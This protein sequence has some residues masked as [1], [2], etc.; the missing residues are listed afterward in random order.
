MDR[1][2]IETWFD[3]VTEL[4]VQHNYQPDCIYNMDE[5]GFAVGTSQ[6]SR[7]LVNIREKSSWKI[8][9]GRQEWITA[10]EC[11]SAS[12]IA[13]PPLVI[14]KAKHTNSA[15]IPAQ[16]PSNWRFS[17]SNSGWTS[18]SHGY[19]WLTAVFEPT[20]RPLDPIQRRLLIMDGH[21]S[22]ITANFIAYCIDKAIDMLILPPH[23]SHI[24]QPL[25]ISIFAP[26]KRA[27]AAET[28]AV[29]QLDSGR[30]S[31]VEWT[32]MY[33]RARARAFTVVNIQ[34]GWKAS[35]LV[36][37]SPITVLEKYTTTHK[38]HA[39]QPS[40]ASDSHILDLSLLNSSPP[41]RT[42]LR[43]ANAVFNA[44][45]QDSEHLRTPVK[46]YAQRMTSAF[47][48]TQ[49]DLIT[50][51]KRLAFA[52]QLLHTR[53]ARKTGKRVALK[54]K[55]VFSTQEVLQIANEAEEAIAAKKRNKERQIQPITIEV[56][57]I[58]DEA[59]SSV[60]S[61]CE[62]DCIVVAARKLS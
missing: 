34:S 1:Q 31:R 40:V 36:P 15:W 32:E 5:S 49:S 45:I 13:L 62:S 28:D 14:F 4:V 33:I 8:V 52:E 29:S 47:E 60:S 3:A 57:N 12:G 44:E 26:L 38:T 37:L 2:A 53:K 35:G 21:S 56:E 19:E 61:E 18:N 54:G 6:S 7:A 58:E 46:R 41:E 51:R 59:P 11:V 25:D 17:T 10:I 9:S 27:L 39:L 42:E 55:F 20:T 30:I 16:T 22:H 24:L 43:Q 23:S 50:T 48:T